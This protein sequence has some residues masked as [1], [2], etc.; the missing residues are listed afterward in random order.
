[1]WPNIS[2][3]L[4]DFPPKKKLKEKKNQSQSKESELA[5]CGLEGNRT[6]SMWPKIS[7]KLK[8]FPPKKNLKEKKK[9]K[10]R[11]RVKKTNLV[12]VALRE[13][14]TVRCGPKLV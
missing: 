5:G 13:I 12:D 7:L 8:D 2:L 10:I 3:K 4:K 9:K 11:V 1:M 14:E 6:C